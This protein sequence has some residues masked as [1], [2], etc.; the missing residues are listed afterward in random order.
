MEANDNEKALK[1]QYI[2]TVSIFDRSLSQTLSKSD[3]SY[4]VVLSNRE[5]LEDQRNENKHQTTMRI[6]LENTP[7]N[8]HEIMSSLVAVIN[9]MYTQKLLIFHDYEQQ[10]K[11]KYGFVLSIAESLNSPTQHKNVKIFL[12]KLIE[13]CRSIFANFAKI[14]VGPILTLL[15]SKTLGEKLNFFITDLVTMLISWNHVPQDMQAKGEA[16]VLL[17]FLI[18][19]AY[20]ERNEIFNLNLALIKKFVE[21]W[22]EVLDDKISFATLIEM[23]E[24]DDKIICGLQLNAIIIANEMT[25]WVNEEQRNRYVK[26]I[27]RTFNNTS[28]K[29][30]QPGA[31]LLGI[32]LHLIIKEGNSQEVLSI[33]ND[34]LKRLEKDRSKSDLLLE[35]LYG[36]SKGYPMILD[37]FM[38]RISASICT[39][40]RKSKCI[41][42]EMFLARLEIIQDNE[43]Y[44]TLDGLKIRNLFK[45]IEYQ[46]LALHIVNKSIDKLK[47]TEFM[48]FLE[49]LIQLLS[50]SQ[51]DAETRIIIYEIMINASEKYKNDFTERHRTMSV[52]LKGFS[53]P[54]PMIQNRV[55]NFLTRDS[56]LSNLFSMRFQQ[57]LTIYYDSSFETEFLNYATQL[58]LEISINHP[59]S[60]SRPLLTVDDRNNMNFVEIPIVTRSNTQRSL[61]PMFIQSQQKQLLAGEGSQIIQP[62]VNNEHRAFTATL[63]PSTLSQTPQTFNFKHTQ[64]SLFVAFKPQQLDRK[65][66]FST[67][68]SS[69]GNEVDLQRQ[70]QMN[71]E[72]SN[73]DA[74][75]DYLRRR[76]TRASADQKSQNYAMN[77]ISRREF[78]EASQKDKFNQIQQGGLPI[79]YR[80]YRCSDLPDFYFNALAIMLPL[81]ALVK[82]DKAI[83]RDIFIA[84]F[85]SIIK[86]FSESGDKDGEKAFHAAINGSIGDIIQ[87]TKQPYSF[88]V[89][90]LIEM[91]VKSGTFLNLNPAMLSNIL[92]VS[93]ILFLE[94][95]LLHLNKR[96]DLF[97]QV[98]SNQVANDDDDEEM[99]R[100]AKRQKIDNDYTKQQHWIKLVEYN[101]QLK[102]FDV[103]SGI[104]TEKLN[105]QSDDKIYLLRAI[106][107]ESNGKHKDAQSIYKHLLTS[108][109][110]K[111]QHEKDFYYNS[112]FN[113]LANLN[114]WE[115]VKNEVQ[116]QVDCY[117]EI[118]TSNLPFYRNTLLP[119]LMKGELRMTL[120]NDINHEFIS[121]SFCKN[122]M[123]IAHAAPFH[124]LYDS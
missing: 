104:F 57:L 113:C 39:A 80:K 60:A 82:K 8:D 107:L 66:T 51:P 118:W 35:L 31:Q 61:P 19:N 93:G 91:T 72:Q 85:D 40:I 77:A 5:A 74:S 79:L 49:E 4:S 34:K 16:G 111:N 9:F 15:T 24:H 10:A 117:N 86:A 6:T 94:S 96:C 7:I 83:A 78:K 22:S 71:K 116:Q 54:E 36:I 29:I 76:I 42:L 63:D 73:N 23:L 28:P 124:S 92:P 45:K 27:L 64:N 65:S 21:S 123:I 41:C 53:D 115:E 44:R 81:K 52:I 122:F 17:N 87:S 88:L 37:S 112:Y 26:A 14:L 70:I 106:D 120:N 114:D 97:E 48:R 56:G 25:P 32:C 98:K 90:T 121:V 67:Q 30:Y 43:I 3:L 110:F 103:I 62:S 20:N 33:V 119:Q 13:N 102:D 99:E 12:A 55:L 58:L 11:E 69:V 95:Q 84:I 50:L 100:S 38:S 89:S 105:L 1:R 59:Q 75:L 108:Q 47:S 18:K 101:Y 46:K 2:N 68:T 109:D